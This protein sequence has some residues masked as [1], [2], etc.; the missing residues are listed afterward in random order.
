MDG[1]HTTLHTSF[2]C[3]SC[4]PSLTKHHRTKLRN[5]DPRCVMTTMQ[6]NSTYDGTRQC[7]LAHLSEE[8]APCLSMCVDRPHAQSLLPPS[9]SACS[10]AVLL[11]TISSR[12]HT[13]RNSGRSLFFHCPL[14]QR[15]TLHIYRGEGHHLPRDLHPPC[16]QQLMPGAEAAAA[17]LHPPAKPVG[18]IPTPRWQRPLGG[19]GATNPSTGTSRHSKE[20]P[21]CGGSNRSVGSSDCPTCVP[22]CNRVPTPTGGSTTTASTPRQDT[23]CNANSIA[24]SGP[25]TP[26]IALAVD[27]SAPCS[28]NADTSGEAF[29]AY[30]RSNCIP[31]LFNTL[32]D[33]LLRDEPEDPVAYIAQWLRRRRDELNAVHPKKL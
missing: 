30:M 22:I 21:A 9:I 17:D 31:N 6:P 15:T 5:I 28:I 20:A 8:N 26:T 2:W 13:S 32:G 27:G 24:C 11:P 18:H 33:N 23:A 7:P 1:S 19:G 16:V 3:A 10:A 25:S 29:K 14:T 12:Y 4:E